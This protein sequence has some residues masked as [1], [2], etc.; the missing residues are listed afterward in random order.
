[1]E[2]LTGRLRR[3]VSARARAEPSDS[4]LCVV[5]L[6]HAEPADEPLAR[7]PRDFIERARFFEEMCGACDNGEIRRRTELFACLFVQR[8]HVDV[9]AAD[10]EHRR[11]AHA[12]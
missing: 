1:M 4:M 8:E 10:N 6:R 2:Q 12:P 5:N 11:C 9:F 7:Q 3:A